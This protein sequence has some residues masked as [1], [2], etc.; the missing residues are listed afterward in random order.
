M[1]GR[2]G[3]A[4]AGAVMST[5][6]T[7]REPNEAEM[8]AWRSDSPT[9]AGTDDLVDYGVRK[10]IAWERS[11]AEAREAALAREVAELR[12]RLNF[13][14][15]YG[16]GASASEQADASRELYMAVQ[17]AEAAEQRAEER[18][19]AAEAKAEQRGLDYAAAVRALAAS[20]AREAELRGEVERLEKRVNAWRFWAEQHVTACV[21]DITAR[22][23]IDRLIRHIN[24]A[25]NDRIARS[26]AAHEE[27]RRKSAGLLNR[28]VEALSI[29]GCRT[30]DLPG[31]VRN[32]VRQHEEARRERDEE[33]AKFQRT[34]A[35]L[36][37]ADAAHEETRRERDAA[38]RKHDL[39]R[40]L[41][42]SA[43]ASHNDAL[44]RI[45]TMRTTVVRLTE[46]IEWAEKQFSGIFE[47]FGP[48]SRW[49]NTAR[50]IANDAD[51]GAKEM[52]RVRALAPTDTKGGA[53]RSS[54][55]T[56]PE[57]EKTAQEQPGAPSAARTGAHGGGVAAAPEPPQD[58]RHTGA[59]LTHEQ[60]G[61]LVR[62]A[63]AR[64]T[65]W[66][67]A[68][69]DAM[70]VAQ[71][72]VDRDLGGAP[73]RR[74]SADAPPAGYRV[75]EIID[76]S[77]RGEGNFIIG[78]RADIVQPKLMHR[79]EADAVAACHAHRE[80]VIGHPT[81]AGEPQ[82]ERDAFGAPPRLVRRDETA[83]PRNG[84]TNE[85]DEWRKAAGEPPA[86]EP[87][88][89][90]LAE[91]LAGAERATERV[92]SW[93]KWKRELSP[94][95]DA[96]PA[97][98]SNAVGETE[99]PGAARPGGHADTSTLERKPPVPSASASCTSPS[100]A[101]AEPPDDPSLDAAL[102]RS[103]R[104]SVR[105]VHEASAQPCPECAELEASLA[106]SVSN[107]SKAIGRLAKAEADLTAT[108]EALAAAQ[109]ERDV[110][111]DRV[112]DH[113]VRWA[114]LSEERD[115]AREALAYAERM[116]GKLRCAVYEETARA[117]AAE[118]ACA[119]LERERASLNLRDAVLRQTDEQLAAERR[120][121]EETR[122]ELEK[123]KRNTVTSTAFR[124]LF[125]TKEAMGAALRKEVAK[126]R[127]SRDHALHMEGEMRSAV[128]E[129]TARA[130]MAER[131]RDA[132]RE[133]Q[134]AAEERLAD[135]LDALHNLRGHHV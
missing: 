97:K 127:A 101:A 40:K 42:K 115:E 11:R 94:R 14:E 87:R 134:R 32:M 67:P 110:A 26:E 98:T 111:R 100:P 109:R 54:E 116:E 45:A 75:R 61:A 63:K 124:R 21:D 125:R 107:T 93:P 120:A 10:G 25:A 41:W 103:L 73:P 58:R 48:L 65:A 71:E 99:T 46:A 62:W 17:A 102:R 119:E 108:R 86:A 91:A 24:T 113:E 133:A 135:V 56:V 3:V 80:S 55:T 8:E 43:E 66:G 51:L 83:S 35:L 44:R 5:P 19:R 60:T 7:P 30:D 90:T 23:A 50:A 4:K 27:T 89:L 68:F 13:D 69:N 49:T 47:Y 96:E 85:R 53:H 74:D 6:E 59:W 16:E 123:A 106:L 126:L 105:V 79:T 77:R 64:T 38:Q 128:Y 81:V 84:M 82:P 122:R 22:E 33:S 52:R 15:E 37:K 31:I 39:A 36:V 112:A 72:L 29:G 121:H 130:D 92:A 28:I 34:H 70:A 18:A 20:E 117:D 132:A 57:A 76:P 78:W 118:A 129:E 1:G 114:H 104:R 2:A 12:E 131:Q 9:H 88:T 95:P